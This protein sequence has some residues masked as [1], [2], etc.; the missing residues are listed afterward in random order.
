VCDLLPVLIG[1]CFFNPPVVCL[2]KTRIFNI[3]ALFQ[4]SYCANPLEIYSYLFNQGIGC[5]LARFYD[6]WASELEK[7]GNTKKADLIYLR[8]IET[9]AQ[10]VDLLKRQHRY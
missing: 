7:L 10:P 1:K 8:G 3:W 4:T 5:G 6:T 9:G 2:I